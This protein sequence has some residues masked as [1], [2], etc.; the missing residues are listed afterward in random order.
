MRWLTR[1]IHVAY[2]NLTGSIPSALL[3]RYSTLPFNHNCF[4]DCSLI[5]QPWCTLPTPSDQISALVDLYHSTGGSQ[6]QTST[7]WVVGDPCVNG[8][9]N[10]S[11]AT[12]GP[13]CVSSNVTYVTEEQRTHACVRLAF[14]CV[15]LAFR[16]NARGVV[17]LLQDAFPEQQPVARQYS[18]HHGQPDCHDVSGKTRGSAV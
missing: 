6:W 13:G 5:P 1:D 8:W 9:Y 12:A 3:S 16:L 7:K 14:R 11:C 17:A 2:N 10:V 18:Q 4:S 15:R